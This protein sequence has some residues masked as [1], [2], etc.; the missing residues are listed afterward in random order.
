MSAVRT[1]IIGITDVV[2]KTMVRTISMKEMMNGMTVKIENG[3][4]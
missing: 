2:E 3:L 1:V 4:I